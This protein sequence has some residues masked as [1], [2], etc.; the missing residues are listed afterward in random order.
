[1][2]EPSDVDATLAELQQRLDRLQRQLGD[3]AEPEPV[4]PTRPT[5][6]A[7]ALA[8]ALSRG[9]DEETRAAPTPEQAGLGSDAHGHLIIAQARA[10]AQQLLDDAHARVAD[11]QAEGERLRAVR[12][13][14]RE[15]I[16]AALAQAQATL[17]AL[18]EPEPV[19]DEDD[20]ADE[21]DPVL[22]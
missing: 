18:D 11:L 6:T 3:V 15:S 21:G 8:A 4:A 14:L 19:S 5:E 10:E 12:D 1:M 16:D 2:P 13:T 9:D 20:D 17:A 22:A 7:A